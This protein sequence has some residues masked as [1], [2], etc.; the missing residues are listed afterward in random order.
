MVE[1]EV[2]SSE[3]VYE[4]DPSFG[5]VQAVMGCRLRWD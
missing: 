4:G 2:K 3:V 1:L 5:V